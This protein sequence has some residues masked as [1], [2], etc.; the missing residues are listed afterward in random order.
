MF[1]IKYGNIDGLDGGDHIRL[2]RLAPS[3]DFTDPIHVSI[4][5]AALDDKPTYEAL[6]YC[7]GDASNKLLIFCDG[8][9]FSVTE[10]LEAALRHLRRI[11]GG[12]RVLWVDAICINQDGIAER[13][14]QVSI[15][16]RIYQTASRVVVWLGEASADSDLVFPLC[17]D[18]DECWSDVLYNDSY[19]LHGAENMW[20]KEGRKVYEEKWRE[21]KARK[22]RLK[23]LAV[24]N[25]DAS[26]ESV[27]KK[28][29]GHG[30]SRAGIEGMV[31]GGGS[32]I[33]WPTT[34]ESIAFSNLIGRPWFNRCWVIQEVALARDVVI[35]CGT[36]SIGWDLFVSSLVMV[37]QLTIFDE[38]GFSGRF[39]EF[40]NGNLLLLM[41]LRP[42]LHQ[43]DYVLD[44][45]SNEIEDQVKDKGKNESDE[46][47]AEE[48]AEMEQADEG[49]EKREK[50]EG[51][52][53]EQEGETEVGSSNDEE[54][55]VVDLLWLLWRARH[56]DATDPRDKVFSV[57]GLIKKARGQMRTLKPDYTISVKQCYERA[58]LAVL[59]YTKNLDLLMTDRNTE[60]KLSLPS[61][62]P[63]WRHARQPMP[64]KWDRD[65]DIE[66]DFCA[67]L[68]SSAQWSL[69]A[70]VTN[71][72]LLILSGYAF[73]EVIAL[74]EIL[75]PPDNSGDFTPGEIVRSVT[76]FRSFWNSAVCGLGGYYNTLI[77]WEKLALSRDYPR[78]PTGEDP[79]T[80]YAMTLCLGFIS[81]PEEALPQFRKWCKALQ[82]PKAFSFLRKLKLEWTEKFQRS[83]SGVTGIISTI[84]SGVF[85]DLVF[86][87]A[88]ANT[89]YRRL[90]RTKKG[91]L[92]LVPG[93]SVVG[94][95]ISLFR[96][97]R[98]PLVTRTAPHK[99]NHRI[100]GP[101]LVYG[102]MHGEAW[103]VLLTR[104]MA[105]E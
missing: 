62:V 45:A 100:I 105:V 54:P 37:Q 51:N 6:S 28:R 90:A 24:G 73:D 42:K 71:E 77:Q 2:L 103:D 32:L 64:R 4:T 79:E 11:D 46:H 34:E 7:W 99:R 63:D 41:E 75:I 43:P 72:N 38:D 18:I 80:A 102:I 94:D 98:L 13:A 48:V 68:L 97:A 35:Q 70:K 92:A 76:K 30:I 12:D 14:N 39:D 74:E 52:G 31:E 33:R 67:S 19:D 88:S 84:T 101:S 20:R 1:K 59:S 22:A 50:E 47:E 25:D 53:I 87:N 26:T 17:A 78:Y 27:A 49:E 56:L 44:K 16:D 82:G 104:D 61:W 8:Q 93:D 55:T 23:D 66:K 95:H 86:A 29:E 65:A 83:L 5:V 91:Y 89:A 40:L 96:G 81:S 10:S 3:K 21:I 36:A 69:E 9:P 58:A 15:M 60:S 57:L 85:E